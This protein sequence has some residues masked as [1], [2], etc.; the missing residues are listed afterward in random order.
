MECIWINLPFLN[1]WVKSDIDKLRGHKVVTVMYIE[2]LTFSS[3]LV[4]SA[5][6]NIKQQIGPGC[7]FTNTNKLRRLLKHDVL[8]L[9]NSYS[10]SWDDFSDCKL[11]IRMRN[12]KYTLTRN[13]NI[14]S[15]N[16]VYSRGG[17]QN[18]ESRG[19]TST[20]TIFFLI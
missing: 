6:E 10:V 14:W 17:D 4:C 19:K 2:F 13:H 5:V 16:S 15:V 9:V 11:L 12:K 8:N 20:K 7:N 18:H 3:W 1:L